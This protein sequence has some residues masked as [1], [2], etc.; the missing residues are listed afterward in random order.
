MINDIRHGRAA[1]RQALLDKCVQDE[2]RGCNGGP[3][4]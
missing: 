4:K 2:D 1:A 3:S